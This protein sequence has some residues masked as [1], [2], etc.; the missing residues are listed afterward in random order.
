MSNIKAKVITAEYDEKKDLI[1]LTL[2]QETKEQTYCF[3]SVDYLKN[4]GGFS[5]AMLKKIRPSHLTQH[6]F[7]LL[8]KEIAFES[9]GKI[10]EIE[11]QIDVSKEEQI[12]KNCSLL[13]EE[14]ARKLHN[15]MNIAK[16]L[17][18]RRYGA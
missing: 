4:V 14:A 17:H 11:P 2:R 13:A 6:C 5:D 18:K 7:D 10:P 8:G 15:E 3:P 1:I 12:N 9:R 16:D